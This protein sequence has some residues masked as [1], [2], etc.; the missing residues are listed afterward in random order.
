MARSG[1]GS[2]VISAGA[3]GCLPGLTTSSQPAVA[4][5]VK[6]IMKM[7]AFRVNPGARAFP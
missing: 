7:I 5:M 3:A 1:R 6:T 2:E 4:T